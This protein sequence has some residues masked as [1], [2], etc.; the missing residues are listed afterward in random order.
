MRRILVAGILVCALC[1]GASAQDVS[2]EK[3]V[4]SLNGVFG[5]H[6][7]TRAS[8]AKGVCVTGSFKPAADAAS[9]SKVPFLADLPVLGNLFKKRGRTKSKA[10]LLIMVTPKVIRVAQRG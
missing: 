1:R 10:E 9:V 3:L 6:A 8:H 2:P 4:D 7:M 5:K